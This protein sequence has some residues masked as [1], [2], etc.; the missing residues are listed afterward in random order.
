MGDDEVV[1]VGAYLNFVDT[2][3]QA[4]AQR[5]VDGLGVAVNEN[6]SNGH[7]YLLGIT[8]L[9]GSQHD[10]CGVI[11]DSAAGTLTRIT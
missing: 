4:Q 10:Y 2:L 8:Q 7:K 5:K 11:A 3:G 9:P 6:R 1:T